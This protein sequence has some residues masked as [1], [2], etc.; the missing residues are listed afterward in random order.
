M[1]GNIKYIIDNKP[2][3][4]I[5]AIIF[6]IFIIIAILGPFLVKDPFET[7]TSESLLSPSFNH[8]M[9]TD[10]FGRDI[11]SR[12]VHSARLDILLGIIISFFSLLIGSIL[13]VIAG[14]WGGYIDEIIMRIND[15]IL[16]FPGFVL[17]LIL[18]SVL[19]NNT[20]NVVMDFLTGKLVL[21][22]MYL[23]GSLIFQKTLYQKGLLSNAKYKYNKKGAP[24]FKT[25]TLSVSA[26]LVSGI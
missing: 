2:L 5:G 16:A 9:G 18:V 25:E 8:L 22:N 21:D 1:K 15:I 3:A 17:A 14:Y 24:S 7:N 26:L 10:K 19:G 11:F 20:I 13:G 6:I 4:V 12:S 23:I